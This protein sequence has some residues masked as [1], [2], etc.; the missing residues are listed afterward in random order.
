MRSRRVGRSRR[1]RVDLQ[2]LSGGRRGGGKEE[3]R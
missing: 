3:T 1:G 2:I